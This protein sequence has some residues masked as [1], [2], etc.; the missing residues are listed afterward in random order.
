MA[1][2]IEKNQYKNWE[3]KVNCLEY[4]YLKLVYAAETA[5]LKS[6]SLVQK[7]VY[8]RDLKKTDFFHA[9]LEQIAK[10]N[11]TTLERVPLF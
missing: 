7:H 8:S 5:S 10:L 6:E 4:N 3:R 9:Y 1:E 11:D 2:R